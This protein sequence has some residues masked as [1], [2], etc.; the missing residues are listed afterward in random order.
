[1]YLKYLIL[2]YANG[3]NS[4]IGLPSDKMIEMLPI[5]AEE[6]TCLLNASFKPEL[7]GTNNI[8]VDSFI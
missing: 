5:V 8:N 6:N 4:H 2:S 7:G 3:G 1:M